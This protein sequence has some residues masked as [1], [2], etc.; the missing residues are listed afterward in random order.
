MMGSMAKKKVEHVADKG[1]SLTLNEVAAW[2]QD[3]MRSGAVGGELVTARVTFGGKLQKIG[4][5]VE[6]NRAER[7]GFDEP[8]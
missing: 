5:D 8:R 4:V 1:Q 2:V 7:T 3:A 6:P